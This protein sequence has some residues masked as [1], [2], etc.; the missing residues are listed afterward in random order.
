[1]KI[2]ERIESDSVH[3]PNIREAKT[4]QEKARAYWNGLNEWRRLSISFDKQRW[5]Y[6]YS[7]LW[8]REKNN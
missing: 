6:H 7:Q 2:K 3:G 1:M 5:M 8:I 4:R